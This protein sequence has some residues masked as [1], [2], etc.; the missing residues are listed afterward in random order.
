[1]KNKLFIFLLFF[2]VFIINLNLLSF[3]NAIEYQ[4]KQINST[5]EYE[6]DL[7][8]TTVI[9]DV[10]STDQYYSF[11]QFD[12]NVNYA[13]YFENVSTAYTVKNFSEN[14]NNT[15]KYMNLQ[16][17]GTSKITFYPGNETLDNSNYGSFISLYLIIPESVNNTHFD[18]IVNSDRDLSC[19]IL[20]NNS[21]YYIGVVSSAF[22]NSTYEYETVGANETDIENKLIVLELWHYTILAGQRKLQAKIVYNLPYLT[23]SKQYLTKTKSYTTSITFGMIQFNILFNTSLNIVSIDGTMFL[24]LNPEIKNHIEFKQNWYKYLYT[25]TNYPSYKI[26]N[27]YQSL[28]YPSYG[29]YS[30]YSKFTGFKD[31]IYDFD[32]V[33]SSFLYNTDLR[34][35]PSQIHYTTSAYIAFHDYHHEYYGKMHRIQTSNTGQWFYR[36][37]NKTNYAEL[38]FH[39]YHDIAGTY[40]KQFGFI[41]WVSGSHISAI[42]ADGTH[43]WTYGSSGWVDQGVKFIKGS[44]F[45]LIRLFLDN[46]A[47]ILYVYIDDTFITSISSNSGYDLDAFKGTIEWVDNFYFGKVSYLTNSSDVKLIDWDMYRMGNT[48]CLSKTLASNEIINFTNPLPASVWIFNQSFYVST[49]FEYVENISFTLDFGLIKY[50]LIIENNQFIIQMLENNIVIDEYSYT[51]Y[52]NMIN[53]N[54]RIVFSYRKDFNPATCFS[55]TYGT[56]MYANEKNFTSGYQ[57]QN[58]ANC[59]YFKANNLLTLILKDLHKFDWSHYETNLHI[60]NNNDLKN[61]NVQ[62]LYNYI[63]NLPPFTISSEYILVDAYFTNANITQTANISNVLSTFEFESTPVF[64]EI[65]GMYG[66]RQTDFNDTFQPTFIDINIYSS[67]NVNII[68]TI[69][70]QTYI[71]YYLKSSDVVNVVIAFIPSILI[72]ILFPF[73]LYKRFKKWGLIIGIFISIILL[74]VVNSFDITQTLL[75]ESI[76]ILMIFY[77]YKQQQ[78]SKQINDF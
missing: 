78:R 74:S 15:L 49:D 17:N 35:F 24:D 57:P 60:F 34:Y 16:S 6:Y 4:S 55:L 14:V 32:Y 27:K 25:G 63:V 29:D 39:L 48:E 19:R 62:L 73:V 28:K 36:K 38:K 30:N 31:S 42:R 2:N 68:H 77:L 46:D 53:N 21:K 3:S 45:Y 52:N 9:D 64:I 20:K 58:D 43:L 12:D 22:D 33:N 70:L 23:G 26:I 56:F 37:F 41:E 8:P 11:A 71:L 61:D 72:F 65:E 67:E 5:L 44:D 50:R 1:M 10:Y 75:L 18:F 66:F 59:V 54:V 51:K 69:Y 13:N 47:N 40:Y 7:N 76:V